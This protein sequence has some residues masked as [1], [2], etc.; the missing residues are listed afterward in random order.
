[1]VSGSPCGSFDSLN[2]NTLRLAVLEG[3]F[4][5]TKL[6]NL[7]NADDDNCAGASRMMSVEDSDANSASIH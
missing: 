5:S 1:M 6:D 2:N 7:K 4:E 3:L